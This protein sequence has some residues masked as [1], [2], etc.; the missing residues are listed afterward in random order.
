MEALIRKPLSPAFRMAL[1]AGAMQ[2]VRLHLSSGSDVNATDEKGRSP[3]ILAASRGRL[4]LCQFL[5]AKGA[6][7]SIRDHEG[8]DALAMAQTKGQTEI[9]ALLAVAAE[10]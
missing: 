9:A 1:L 3:L 10:M 8:N 2:S 7:P 5:L 4:D 6:D